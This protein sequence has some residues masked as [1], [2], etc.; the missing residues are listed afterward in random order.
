MSKPSQTQTPRLKLRGYGKAECVICGANGKTAARL[1]KLTP[2][3]YVTSAAGHAL[4]PGKG[5]AIC[6]NCFINAAALPDSEIGR[7]VGAALLRAGYDVY[8]RIVTGLGD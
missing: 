4:K 6:E 1:A 7:K 2:Y 8:K 5:A 3:V